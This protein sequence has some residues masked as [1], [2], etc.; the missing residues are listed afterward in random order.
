MANGKVA[1]KGM[2]VRELQKILGPEELKAML[3]ECEIA[4]LRRYVNEVAG[5]PPHT[6]APKDFIV[7][8]LGRWIDGDEY[9]AYEPNHV[10]N[11]QKGKKKSKVN[12]STTQDAPTGTPSAEEDEMNTMTSAVKHTGE[13]KSVPPK[14]KKEKVVVSP[15]IPQPTGKTSGETR[16]KFILNLLI[17]NRKEKLS[18]A[19]LLKKAQ[20]EFSEALIPGESG[21]FSIS[22]QRYV[23]NKDRENGKRGLKNT[24]PE[25]VEYGKKESAPKKD[26]NGKKATA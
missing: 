1:T 13:K 25:F 11:I 24:D 2:S 17:A 6:S 9:W 10:A 19:E 18:D 5:Q 21:T 22:R 7:A 23:A 26:G 15:V 4:D 8:A 12:G 16:A 14:A 3:G 20:K